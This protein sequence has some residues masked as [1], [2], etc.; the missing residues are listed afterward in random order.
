MTVFRKIL[1]ANR[2]EIAL[3][4]MRTCRAM[5]I[6]TVAVY[7]DAD[8]NAP[9]VRFADEAVRLGEAPVKDSYLN[10]EKILEAAKRTGADAIHPGYGFLSEN[11]EFA[12]ACAAA[13]IVF[14]GPQ[15]EAIRKMG[16][17]S[18]ARKLAAA[19]GCPVVPG[20]DGEDQQ[21]ETLRAEI[22]KIG[23]PVLIKA[24]AGGGGK[25]MRI[26]RSEA[27]IREAIEGARRE[28]E[29]AFGNGALLLEKFIE[30]ARHVEIQILGDQHGNLVHLF[31]R[32]CSLQRRHQKIIEESPSPAV[33]D[34]LRAKMGEAAV[35]VG[36]AIRYS[37]AG[38]VEFILNPDNLFYFIEVNTRLQVEHPVTEAITGLDLV[39]LQI[40]IAEGKPLPLSQTELKTRGH[41]IEARLYAEDPAN[42]FLPATGKLHDWQLPNA[43]EGLRIDA[44]VEA[45]SE[46]G[47]YYDPM[48][49]KLIAHAD[50]R[51]TAIRKLSYALRQL[52]V[53]GVTTNRDFLIRQI[54]HPDFARGEAHTGFIAEHLD[55][56][57]GGTNEQ[58]DR[59]SAIAVAL[60]L[61]QTS[62][63][64]DSLLCQ[65]PPSYRNNP[66]RAPAIKL[67]IGEQ[68]TEVSWQFAGGKFEVTAT[69]ASFTA[70]VLACESGSIR[71]E[72]DGVQREFR[73]TE[74]DDVLYVHS[75]LGSCTIVRLARHPVPK[76]ATEQG[77]ASSPMPG[78]VLKI[79]VSEGQQILAGDALLV[80]EAMKMEQ[81]IRAAA[82]GVVESIKVLTGQVVSPGDVLVQVRPA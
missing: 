31:E 48:L 15:P 7:S 43:V 72:I 74:V 41:A 64:A 62:Q 77:A 4:V 70:E 68:E 35:K 5:G 3:R 40:E 80:L 78:V 18:P 51:A 57:V 26:V 52:S 25:G 59:A 54:E 11:A 79:L 1:I 75:S 2:G 29:K 39:K 8:A 44:G 69:G 60:Y 53:Q 24:S 23:F 12:E 66:Y 49:A 20:Y 28:A 81:T 13:G 9:H 32:D 33:S 22:L 61:Q 50:D 16:L 38:T 65:I 67:K 56:L 37:N 42:D 73:I 21:D 63:T 17:K 10:S 55:E 82:D 14:I 47:I 27:E 45:G 19:A 36:R 71:L 6:T 34:E 30:R 46:V 58:L 76:S